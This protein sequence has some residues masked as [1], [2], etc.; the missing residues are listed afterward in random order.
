MGALTIAQVVIALQGIRCS[1]EFCTHMLQ[2]MAVD[3]EL[4]HRTTSTERK[5]RVLFVLEL[6]AYKAW[7]GVLDEYIPRLTRLT[8]TPVVA[9]RRIDI[10][11]QVYDVLI[12]TGVVI[13]VLSFDHLWMNMDGVGHLL[14]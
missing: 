1:T 7:C 8:Q 4:Q 12:G 10:G 3:D 6:H 2:R 13:M 14:R 9:C 5:G 11:R